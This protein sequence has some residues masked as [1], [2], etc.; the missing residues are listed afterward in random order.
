VQEGGVSA[1][2]DDE[3]FLEL[4]TMAGRFDFEPAEGP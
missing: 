1:A 4:I 2:G 3:D